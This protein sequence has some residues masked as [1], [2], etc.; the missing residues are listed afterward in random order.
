[1]TAP[2]QF[3]VTPRLAALAASVDESFRA[4]HGRQ[5]SSQRVGLSDS[6]NG[7]RE[8]GGPQAYVPDIERWRTTWRGLGVAASHDDEYEAL[9]GRYS[10][11][12]RHYHTV[13]HLDECFARLDEARHLAERIHEVELA[14]WFHDAVYRVRNDDNEE[15][16]ASWAQATAERAGLANAVR[17]RL[18]RLILATKHDAEP[19]CPD[20]A[21][22]VDVDLAILGAAPERFDEYERQ[23]RQE[24]SWVPDVLFRRKRR[25]VLEGFLARSHLYSTGHFRTCYEALARANLRRSIK[26]LGS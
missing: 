8:C 21:L 9:I 20:A 10:E 4:R 23:V 1:L 24:Y 18:Q 12:H 3:S 7:E 16:S 5:D 22:L 14:L 6:K 26:R 2:R 25:E 17:E 19:D 13:Q 15:Q 11:A